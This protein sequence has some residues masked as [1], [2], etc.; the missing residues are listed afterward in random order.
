MPNFSA[1]AV[2]RLKDGNALVLASRTI[3]PTGQVLTWTPRY[4]RPRRSSR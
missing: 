2:N 3:T 4:S 1:E